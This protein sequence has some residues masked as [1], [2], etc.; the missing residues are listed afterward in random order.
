MP[1]QQDYL[2]ACHR[3]APKTAEVLALVAQG[4]TDDEIAAELQITPRAVRGR[5]ERFYEKTD[6][7]G[8]RAGAWAFRH[9][10][11]CLHVNSA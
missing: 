2:K 3:V 10:V 9:Q 4:L 5:L 8:R 6:L 7:Q 1:I 11:C